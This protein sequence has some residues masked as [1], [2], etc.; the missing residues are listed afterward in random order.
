MPEL[1]EVEV[2][3]AAL[4][5]AVIGRRVVEVV[6]RERRLR[7]AV[8]RDLPQTLRGRCVTGVSRHGKLL[9][10]IL[11]EGAVVLALH[12]GMSGTL[13][14][15]RAAEP[16]ERHDHVAFALDDDHALVFHDP[17]RFGLIRPAPV[18]DPLRQNRGLDP[19]QDGFTAEAL[20]TLT[21]KRRRSIKSTLMDQSLVAG[22]GNIYVNEILAT[23]GIRP[24]RASGRLSRRE[25]EAIVTA[26]RTVLW[27]AIERGGSSISDFRHADGKSGGFQTQFLVYDR[28]GEPCRRCRGVIRR[29]V[30]GG[31]STFYCPRCQR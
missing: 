26:T 3:A 18:G 12:L 8:P 7:R 27:A 21:R 2:V 14:L 11:D 1:P 28:A 15:R 9:R 20:A 4:R 19:V 6:V 30:L 17:R 23:A 24:G 22:L 10:M 25:H 31:R 5:A 29:R 13:R 16:L